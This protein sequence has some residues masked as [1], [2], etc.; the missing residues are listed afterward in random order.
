MMLTAIGLRSR[1]GM[2]SQRRVLPVRKVLFANSVGVSKGNTAA[3]TVGRLLA[4]IAVKSPPRMRD[5]GTVLDLS[6]AT[7]KSQRRSK[8]MRK[9]VFLPNF[10]TG[11][12]KYPPTSF[13]LNLDFG[14]LGVSAVGRNAALAFF[15]FTV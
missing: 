10:G 1:V 3:L 2:L 8:E 13:R 12:L 5:V 11:P 9:N 14:K 4:L 6:W 15:S 7:F